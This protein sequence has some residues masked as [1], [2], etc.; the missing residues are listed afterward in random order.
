MRRDR[1]FS[2]PA[3]IALTGVAMTGAAA[4][5]AD[6]YFSGVGAIG[7]DPDGDLSF[8][9]IQGLS[10]DGSVAVGFSTSPDGLRAIRWT[11]SGG[12]EAL[13]S[14]LPGGPYADVASDVSAD[15]ALIVG[16]TLSGA[17]ASGGLGEATSWAGG[18]VAGLGFVDPSSFAQS[19]AVAVSADG[20]TIVGLS[21][22]V[23]AVDFEATR[24]V[25][26][27]PMSLGLG[28]GS[29]ATGVSS[30]GS[31][32]VGSWAGTTNALLGAFLWTERGV[33]ELRD[34]AAGGLLDFGATALDVSADGSRAVGWATDAFEQR[35]VLW[36]DA[37]DPTDLGVPDDFTAGLAN[38]IS[39]DGSIIVGSASGLAGETA[40]IWTADTGSIEL[41]A[42]L[43]PL[44]GGQLAGWTLTSAD[45]ISADG[46]T[47]AGVGVNPL[48]VSEGW[49]AQI[50][51][52]G[53]AALALWPMIRGRRRTA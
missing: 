9:R 33:T 42:Y 4:P 45:A 20:S 44:V 39:D 7:A 52:P 26:G 21:S 2:T 3:L 6:P 38:A 36:N 50:P 27:R 5:G 18:T 17:A 13:P 49:V 31:T 53:T 40:F 37:G 25:Q 16:S 1:H 11:R 12:L 34:L 47:F 48:G 23:G 51:A 15:G 29:S 41:A 8:S 28:S 10:A 24:W 32:I 46:L 14:L 43:K 19:R 30:D 22:N 35:P